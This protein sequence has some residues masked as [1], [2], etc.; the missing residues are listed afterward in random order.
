[1]IY[2]TEIALINGGR[3]EFRS[4]KRPDYDINETFVKYDDGERALDF[5]TANLAYGYQY[6]ET[7]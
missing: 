6:W 7:E 5:P 1:M 3:F 2:V 4:D